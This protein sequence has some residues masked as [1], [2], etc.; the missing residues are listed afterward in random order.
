MFSLRR[1]FAVVAK[2]FVQMRRDRLTFA[3][4]VG[5]PI[6]QLVLFGFAI[7]SDPK[8]LPTA[9]LSNDNGVFAR[10]V[11]RAMENTGYFKVV[12]MVDS[13]ADIE[14]ML[15]DGAVQFAVTIPPDFGRD[16]QRGV[17]PTVLVEADATDPAATSNALSA[18]QR[19]PETALRHDL[20]G[21][22]VRLAS[23]PP[24]F[25]IVTHR[26]YNPEGIT[27]YNIVP[28]L[29]GVILTMTMII[30]TAL[31]VTREIERGTMENLLSM[32]I[33]PSEVLLGKILPYTAVGAVQVVIVLGAARVIFAVP[34]VGSLGLFG[35]IVT[36]FVVTNLAMGVMF[37]TIARNQLQA[38]QMAI[39]F[40]LPS[41][42]LSGFMFPLR[43]MP[44]W[45]QVIGEILPPIS[46]ESRAESCSRGADWPMSCPRSGRFWPSYSPF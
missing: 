19:L 3:M 4:M 8:S 35:A 2:E 41:I 24:P 45:A 15:K 40:F 17:R 23:G 29:I 5:I 21:P 12:A 30:M 22:L 7:N 26:A 1:F 14:R 20:T 13:E 16:L 44:A 31:A 34:F 37:S 46:C 42:M 28:A 27:Q 18:L 38:M 32:P 11:V 10:S 25:R 9:V 33:R 36:L 39:F 43:G 6:V